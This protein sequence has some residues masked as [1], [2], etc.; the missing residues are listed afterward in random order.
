MLL[1]CKITR[2]MSS[3]DLLM[4]IWSILISTCNLYYYAA[5]YLTLFNVAAAREKKTYLTPTGFREL[6]DGIDTCIVN[7]C[8]NI[9][10]HFAC[11]HH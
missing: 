1:T 5:L 3:C 9:D 10:Y 7:A 4:S 8:A 2:I 11:L 6:Q